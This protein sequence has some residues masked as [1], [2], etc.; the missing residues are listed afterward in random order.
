MEKVWVDPVK[1]GSPKLV[2]PKEA[3]I[4]VLTG[5]YRYRPVEPK[6]IDL[7]AIPYPDLVRLVNE[8]ELTPESRKKDD[9]IRALKYATRDMRAED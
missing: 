7:D 3:R 5:R 2:R 6:P 9:L 4:L 8:R 1:R